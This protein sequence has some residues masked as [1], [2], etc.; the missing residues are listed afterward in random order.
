MIFILC[1]TLTVFLCSIPTG[2]VLM[3]LFY[4]IDPREQGSKNIGMSNVWRLKG[5][6]IGVCTLIGDLFKSYL[7]LL[8][9]HSYELSQPSLM[10]IAFVAVL[11]HCYSIYL[12]GR[13]G[14]GVASAGGV[15]LFFV[16]KMCLILAVTWFSVRFISKKAS[17]ASICTT[18]ATLLLTAALFPS[19]LSLVS[20]LAVLIL[21]RHK[22]NIGRIKNKNELPSHLYPNDSL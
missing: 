10:L 14:K 20:S 1:V 22:D 8:I 12:N 5:A 13:G 15:L 9:A 19:I 17:L 16:P 6:A 2:V 7:A 3:T 4:D 18:A 21:W 11:A